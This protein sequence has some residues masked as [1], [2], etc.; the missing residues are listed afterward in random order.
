MPGRKPVSLPNR[1]WQGAALKSRQARRTVVPALLLLV[2]AARTFAADPFFFIQAADPQFGMFAADKNFTQETANW[3]F[4]IANINRLHP[5]F[6]VVSGDL[7]DKAGDPAQIAEYKRINRSLDPSIHLYNVAG[8]HD[9]EN[10]PTPESIA[11]YRKNIG[12]DY[13][14]FREGPVYGIVL[15]SSYFKSPGK[16]PEEAAKQETWLA[17]EL[18]KARATNALPVV[19][20]HIPLFLARPD[21]PEQY[22]NTPRET[23]SR[24]LALL[25]RYNVRYVFAGHLHKNS[26]GKDGDLEMIATSAAGKPLGNDP[27][28]FRIVEIKGDSLDQHYIAFGKLPNKYPIP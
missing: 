26:Y 23:R 18:E 21:E 14:S 24:I 15:N 19:F 13:Y 17:A 2:F 3:T 1:D 10:D 4:A 22:F 16:V 8:N 12:P 7:V 25:H 5:A 9:V 27:S 28:G 20:L 6:L 11:A